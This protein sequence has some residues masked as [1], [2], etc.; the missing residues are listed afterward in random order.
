MKSRKPDTKSV[1]RKYEKAHS[2]NQQIGLYDT[3]S[4]NEAFFIGDQWKGVQA[5]GLPTPVFNFLKRVTLFQVASICTDNIKM[6]ASPLESTSSHELSEIDQVADIVT[7]QF[8][9]IFERNRVVSMLREYVRN[10]AVDGDSCLYS[11]FDTS[12]D[13]GNAVKGDI[14]TEILDNTRVKFGDPN[15]RRVEKQ[16]YI[17]I[18]TRER[19]SAVKKR[20]KDNGIEV[21]DSIGSDGDDTGNDYQ[22][23]VSDKCTVLLYLWR[24]DETDTIWK[25]ETTKTTPVSEPVDTGMKRYP[26]TWLSWDY[27]PNSYHGQALITGLIPNQIFIN[28]LFAMSMISLMTT[29]YPKIVYDKTRVA[30][31]DS[32]VGAAIGVNGGDMNSVARIIDPAQISPQIAQFISLALDT[33]QSL[34]GATD[35]ALGDTRPDNTSAII[36]LQ[37]AS[38][39]PL[40]LVSQSFYQSVEDLGRIYVDMMRVYY[41]ERSVTVSLPTQNTPFGMNIPDRPMTIMW[42][43]AKLAEVPIS[44]KLDVGA[45]SYWS[46]VAS[47]QTLDNLLINNKITTLDYLERVPAG[48]IG[49]KQELIDRYRQQ[50]SQNGSQQLAQAA[51]DAASGG[52]GQLVD[53]AQP[54]E[55]SGGKGNGQ[56]QRA[57]NMGSAVV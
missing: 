50:E 40:E 17:I 32:R 1:W 47:M 36:A 20:A 9:S 54:L 52:T 26:I 45:S 16:P 44:L 2:Y 42:D 25:F 15:E 8:D 39:V 21:Y 48:Y 19:V 18:D 4:K 53:T 30:S 24:D 3:V 12:I 11:Y 49:K 6:Q 5:N 56:L 37:R 28:K 46:E 35:A 29:A 55:V 7:K 13:T 31:W 38:N 43:Y 22:S 33:T 23:L 14:V 27:I 57:I 41:G 34:M 10:A 51:P